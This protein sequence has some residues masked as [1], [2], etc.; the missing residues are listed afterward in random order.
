MNTDGEQ[1]RDRDFEARL[2]QR[3]QERLAKFDPDA[4]TFL[5]LV[6]IWS[7]RLADQCKFPRRGP[8][9]EYLT[10]LEAAGL[11]EQPPAAGEQEATSPLRYFWMPETTALDT[12]RLLD[13]QNVVGWA[14]NLG[15]MIADLDPADPAALPITRRWAELARE[16]GRGPEAKGA[17][18][19]RGKAPNEI[20]P[21]LERAGALLT[22]R[23]TG[24]IRAEQ[25][26]EA[27]GWLEAG[28]RLAAI[29][30]ALPD[31]VTLA[32]RRVK[33]AARQEMD[34][35]YLARFIERKEQLAAFHELMTG[36]DHYWALHYLGMGGVGKTMLLRHIGYLAPQAYRAPVAR[37]DF[38][39]LSP[40]YPVRH[41]GQ[42]LLALTEELRQ[43]FTDPEH[44][45]AY[46]ALHDTLLFLHEI[47]GGEPSP[48]DPLANLHRRQF[49]EALGLFA[50]LLRALL[51]TADAARAPDDPPARVL[52][53]LDTCEE[54]VRSHADAGLL[55]HLAATFEIIER[56]QQRVPA[57]RVILAGR[58]LLALGGEDWRV[59]EEQ[60]LQA[61]RG[62]LPIKPYLRLHV[63]RG[64]DEA[65]AHTLFA[66]YETPER[67]MPPALRQAILE[68]S[69]EHGTPLGLPAEDARAAEA[70]PRYSPFNLSLYSQWCIDDSTL[71]AER[72]R[73]VSVDPYVELRIIRRVTQEPLRRLLPAIVL[74]RRFNAAMLA[75][76][77]SGGPDE[78]PA[79]FQALS[80]Y[81]WLD[82]RRDPDTDE[83]WLEVDPNLYSRLLA[84]YENADPA[85]L[86]DMRR[87]LGSELAAEI[88]ATPLRSQRG[89][90]IAACLTLLQPDEAVRLW[91]EI[92]WRA[93]A[94]ADWHWIQQVARLALGAEDDASLAAQ[95]LLTAALSATQTAAGLQLS[96]TF[97]PGAAWRGVAAILAR[98]AVP[99]TAAPL[100]RWLAARAALGQRPA[101]LRY[102]PPD[103][104]G[105]NATRTLLGERARGEG[106]LAGLA[107][108]QITQLDAALLAAAEA[109]VDAAEEAADRTLVGSDI[110]IDLFALAEK[111]LDVRLRVFARLL[112]GRILALQGFAD[113]A[114]VALLDAENLAAGAAVDTWP[115]GRWADW[116]APASFRH[117]VRLEWLR[118]RL[119]LPFVGPEETP[120][121]RLD[122][123]LEELA[124][125][126][127]LD[128]IDGERLAA[129][130]L[131]RRLDLGPVDAD[132]LTRL[133]AAYRYRADRQP[134]CLAHRQA[135][136]FSL[137]AARAWLTLG[138][139]ARGERLL[140]T[141]QE[142]GTISAAD[143][144]GVA[145]AQ[146]GLSEIA[147]RTRD[148]KQARSLLAGQA[149]LGWPDPDAWAMGSLTGA[150]PVD[151]LPMPVETWDDARLHAWWR[152]QHSLT[153]DRL[154]Q[155]TALLTARLTDEA[156]I[157]SIPYP[158]ME[159]RAR[160]ILDARELSLRTGQAEQTTSEATYL[161][162]RL[163][164]AARAEQ[165]PG[166]AQE[167]L[168]ALLRWI[169]LDAFPLSMG[170]RIS[171]LVERGWLAPAPSPAA[172]AASLLSR[173]I[174]GPAGIYRAAAIALDEGEALALRLPGQAAPLLAQA[175][176]WFVAAEDAVGA[177]QAAILWA[178][179][180]IRGGAF[181]DA[182]AALVACQNLYPRAA[183]ARPADG[184]PDWDFFR[185]QVRGHDP[186]R[187]TEITP[188]WHGWLARLA[189]CLLWEAAAAP[190]TAESW[191]T[192]LSQ[193]E[194][195]QLGPPAP[196]LLPV[197][198]AQGTAPSAPK[199]AF[200]ETTRGIAVIT[201][202]S[203]LLLLGVLVGVYVGFRALLLNLA[204]PGLQSS[205]SNPAVTIGLYAATWLLLIL[206]NVSSRRLRRNLRSWLAAQAKLELAIRANQTGAGE[207]P[208]VG[209]NIKLQVSERVWSWW[210]PFLRWT[211]P[212][213]LE[214]DVP[215]FP[216]GASTAEVAATL[217][218][219]SVIQR[220]AAL[221]E[222]AERRGVAA[223][224]D[225]MAIL[226]ALSWEEQLGRAAAQQA[227]KPLK[228]RFYRTAAAEPGQPFTPGDIRVAVGERWAGVFE[229]AWGRSWSA[230]QPQVGPGAHYLDANDAVRVL[231]IV[232]RPV[233]TSGGPRIQV[234]TGG[235]DVSS[236]QQTSATRSAGE[237]L[238]AA[239][240]TLP[241][242]RLAGRTLILQALPA[243]G[244]GSRE[245]GRNEA[246][247][248]RALAAEAFTGGVPTI[249][250]LPA[251]PADIT[252][253][254][255]GHLAS[256]LGQSSA[257]QARDLQP[258]LDAVDRI[259]A[260][261]AAHRP[262][263]GAEMSVEEV[264]TAQAELAWD[265]TL[266]WR[267]VSEPS[268]QRS[269]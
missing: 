208:G 90:T 86:A 56:V 9:E 50:A 74:L 107:P 242:L 69:T 115:V 75:P 215:S 17:W 41:P 34:R 238:G 232:G 148:M 68:I 47:I 128:Q 124:E 269:S 204:P 225:V 5:A 79:M 236:Y 234:E 45:R 175:H 162:R 161:F 260:D 203:L 31:T 104:A 150:L 46:Q 250:V 194:S 189:A 105:I 39:Y 265:V 117:R 98:L 218:E 97:D 35:R 137:A 141:S 237:L 67:P 200:Y 44:Q 252:P 167:S 233:M 183:A 155:A 95:P 180:A 146:R 227:G 153:A 187:F 109:L 230:A 36:P 12:M 156:S 71:T 40:D 64:F 8:W 133:E 101:R 121:Q 25:L 216:A 197:A 173:V 89:E 256:A 119:D 259:R 24:L 174:P 267:Q 145:A 185:E 179:A 85:A 210:P 262:S 143:A 132:L 172:P 246:N 253:R 135:P 103:A 10:S 214:E 211:A 239:D 29:G 93:P 176:A 205:I 42:L 181:D 207:G 258:W 163:T 209:H 184:L 6:P 191:P 120:A 186:A 212:Q 57:V 72:I 14:A 192:A 26:L 78:Y 196:E 151:E 3:R 171:G 114:R 169:A 127:T 193:L 4:L 22:G 160:L 134:T 94:Q 222:R 81:E 116:R 38:D 249:L 1:S 66:R 123:W 108:H 16:I 99:E 166:E 220:L 229:A 51:R 21:G 92:E 159:A 37:I 58:H 19:R 11:V 52:L 264:T 139:P 223:G 96:R 83:P 126:E 266:F 110:D 198:P 13:R 136:P 217:D 226:A 32:E 158:Q 138:E 111:T 178:L 54:L 30:G 177:L 73:D 112:E 152:A 168:R 251:L 70:Q 231:H 257:S 235:Y 140:L 28:Q 199:P 62:L 82:Y 195:F 33:L 142:Q 80:N 15:R 43:H 188:T 268:A 190:A 118:L 165:R 263:E 48:A 61:G 240:L 206:A 63:I 2:A 213:T 247:T 20:A 53:M 201:I 202:G 228:L 55:P 241:A 27:E 77:F 254:A 106:W 144:A 113:R 157:V 60:V 122:A 245:V 219:R 88:R 125:S 131:T 243:E 18:S 91:S 59:D 129:T 244:I 261:I 7:R 149:T 170:E 147:R 221:A 49:E 76:A 100:A 224:L 84:Y 87:L 248:L 164:A 255:I 23:V 182:H 65:E 130:A 154:E 102:V